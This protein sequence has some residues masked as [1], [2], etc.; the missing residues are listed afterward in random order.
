M[1]NVYMEEYQK[2]QKIKSALITAISEVETWPQ[3]RTVLAN[4]SSKAKLKTYIK[5]NLQ[6]QRESVQRLL[7]EI[8]AVEQDFDVEGT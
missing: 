4:F 2:I 5:A 1:A 6:I 7:N 8:D 3:L